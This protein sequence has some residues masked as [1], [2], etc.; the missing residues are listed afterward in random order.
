VKRFGEIVF[1]ARVSNAGDASHLHGSG[2]VNADVA[3]GRSDFDERGM[4]AAVG[5]VLIF[6]RD[7]E[8]RKL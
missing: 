3:A 6:S 8:S 4:D 7:F 2:D 1:K 5:S